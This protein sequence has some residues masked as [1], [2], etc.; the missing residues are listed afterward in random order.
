MHRKNKVPLMENIKHG[1][2]TT[3]N[4]VRVQFLHSETINGRVSPV[5]MVRDNQ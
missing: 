4:T 2:Y 3:N 1:F 5:Y